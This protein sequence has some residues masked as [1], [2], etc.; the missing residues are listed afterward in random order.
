MTILSEI[1][2][3]LFALTPADIE[4]AR[5]RLSPPEPEENPILVVED[6][7]FQRLWTLCG[8]YERECGLLAHT[9]QFDVPAGAER[10]RIIA[11][12]QRQYTLEKIVREMAWLRARDLAKGLPDTDAFDSLA[13]REDFTLVECHADDQPKLPGAIRLRGVEALLSKLFQE[14]NGED[15]EKPAPPKKKTPKPS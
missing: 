14:A 2:F 5:S 6:D 10:D 12:A 11:L 4:L 3:A 13:L 9:A 8:K 7:D 1:E 15:G